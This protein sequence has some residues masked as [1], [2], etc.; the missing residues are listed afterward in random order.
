MYEEERLS[1]IQD[2]K[3][4]IEELENSPYWIVKNI[5]RYLSWL[6]FRFK[7]RYEEKEKTIASEQGNLVL[8]LDAVDQISSEVPSEEWEKL[9]SDFS[10]NLDHYLYNSPKIDE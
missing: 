4:L 9:P 10:K 8:F 6:K 7:Y 3:Q 1:E 2:K 5:L